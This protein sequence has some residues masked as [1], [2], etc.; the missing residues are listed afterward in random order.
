MSEY[1]VMGELIKEVTQ[2]VV[3][4]FFCAFYMHC[5]TSLVSPE[6]E[7]PRATSFFLLV[8]ETISWVNTS[9]F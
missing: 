1:L 2:I 4:P 5:T 9:G 6:K 8:L 3:V 7:I